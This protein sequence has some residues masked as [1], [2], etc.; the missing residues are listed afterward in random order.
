[1]KHKTEKEKKLADD[2]RL[3]RAW[4]NWHAEELTEA[5]NGPH[6]QIVEPLM[7]ILKRLDPQS[8]KG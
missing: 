2:A 8:G 4:R 7:E 1:V 5:L 6:H 3:L